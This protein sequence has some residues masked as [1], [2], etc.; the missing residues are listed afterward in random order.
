M[1]ILRGAAEERG[2]KPSYL[3]LAA[4]SSSVPAGLAGWGGSGRAEQASGAALLEPPAFQRAGLAPQAQ[5]TALQGEFF[6]V[7]SA[8]GGLDG[9]GRHFSK[10]VVRSVVLSNSLSTCFSGTVVLTDCC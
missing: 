6:Q 3:A 7:F 8:K 5:G 1:F 9:L 10:Q 2:P 4:G